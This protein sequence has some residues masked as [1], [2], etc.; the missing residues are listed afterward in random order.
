MKEKIKNFIKKVT[1][2]Q[3]IIFITITFV[4]NKIL[5]YWLGDWLFSILPL[6][7]SGTISLFLLIEN[8]G[9]AL[10][11]SYFVAFIWLIIKLLTGLRKKDYE[12][13]N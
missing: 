9:R 12:S 11:F 2:K 1:T 3:L 7:V 5:Y 4:F 10:E 6:T 13:V 8:F